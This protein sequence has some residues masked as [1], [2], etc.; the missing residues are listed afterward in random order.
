[1]PVSYSVDTFIE[2]EMEQIERDKEKK[3]SVNEFEFQQ[4]V[5]DLG[6]NANNEELSALFASYDEDGGGTLDTAELKDA[7]RRLQD[8]AA[9]RDVGTEEI[10]ILKECALLLL[11]LVS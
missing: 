9:M 7:L 8:Q 1:M 3:G 4:G 11:A 5:R 2:Q 6:I 10:A